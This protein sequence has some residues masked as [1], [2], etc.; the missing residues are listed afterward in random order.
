[1]W[2]RLPHVFSAS[3]LVAVPVVLVGWT[4]AFVSG[5][6]PGVLVGLHDVHLLAEVAT[7]LIG[8]A[9]VGA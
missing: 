9:I 2:I 8:V 7:D 5:H 3:T 6:S 1:M 4:I